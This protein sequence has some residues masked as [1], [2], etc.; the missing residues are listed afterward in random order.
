MGK[1]NESHLPIPPTKLKTM[2]SQI[3]TPKR[4]AEIVWI[5]HLAMKLGRV[6]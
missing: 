4:L 6:I 5:L 2:I 3:V 1:E